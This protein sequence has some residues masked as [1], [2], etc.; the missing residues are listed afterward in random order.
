MNKFEVDSGNYELNVD[1]HLRPSL[2]RKLTGTTKT[3]TKIQS[4]PIPQKPTSIKSAV[5][6]L[7]FYRKYR[8][9]IIGNRCV[10]EPSCSH[11]SELAIRENG[12]MVG[13]WLTVKRLLRCRP[14]EGGIDL[15]CNKEKLCNTK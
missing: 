15:T 9:P 1:V 6:I 10:F 11:Y 5:L 14:G 8:P 4:L 2:E 13:I 12:L 7:R 3:D